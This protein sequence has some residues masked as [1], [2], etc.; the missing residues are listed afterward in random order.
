M[1]RVNYQNLYCNHNLYLEFIKNDVNI[2]KTNYVFLTD[3]VQSYREFDVEGVKMIYLPVNIGIED[4]DLTKYD[5]RPFVAYVLNLY[6]NEATI[7]KAEKIEL[8][9]TPLGVFT[10]AE[11]N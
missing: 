2:S 7:Q 11:F 3:T 9:K 4:I 8:Y 10:K 6:L 1:Q 5:S